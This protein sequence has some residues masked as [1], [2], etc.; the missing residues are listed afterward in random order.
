MALV[1]VRVVLRVK[2]GAASKKKT[3]QPLKK[4]KKRTM[5]LNFG[6]WFEI[7]QRRRFVGRVIDL[8]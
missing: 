8:V 5:G 7:G 1:H 6:H 3:T 2:V 4:T